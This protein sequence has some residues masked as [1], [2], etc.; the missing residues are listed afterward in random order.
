MASTEQMGTLMTGLLGLAGSFVVG[1][2][3]RIFS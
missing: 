3:A 1:F 2:L